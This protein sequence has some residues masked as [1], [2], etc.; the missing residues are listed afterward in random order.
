MSTEAARPGPNSALSTAIGR[1]AQTPEKHSVNS[2]IITLLCGPSNGELKVDRE[3]LCS[4]SRFFYDMLNSC[5]TTLQVNVDESQSDMQLFLEVASGK[6]PASTF[7][8]RTSACWDEFKRI[9]D[10]ADK[11]D[12]PLVRERCEKWLVSRCLRGRVRCS[13]FKFQDVQIGLDWLSL[14]QKYNLRDLGWYVS[15][16]LGTQ[17]AER[18]WMTAASDALKDLSDPEFLKV[19]LQAV[20]DRVVEDGEKAAGAAEEGGSDAEI[21]NS[22]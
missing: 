9:F 22:G 14:C 17:L 4:H 2:D 3:A 10:I 8:T 18:A 21:V 16:D 15:Y 1:N 6:P 5:D 20:Q 12:S 19:M 11:Y 13:D 7:E